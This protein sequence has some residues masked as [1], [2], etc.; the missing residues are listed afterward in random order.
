[1]AAQDLEDQIISLWGGKDPEFSGAFSG[2][3][4]MQMAL[5]L[6]KNIKITKTDLRKILMKI[7]SYLMH[8]TARKK[9]PRRRYNV[10]GFGMMMEVCRPFQLEML[11]TLN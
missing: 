6:E 4:N 3:S 2:V 1:M 8:V 11:S 9:F 10:L 7:P 5:D